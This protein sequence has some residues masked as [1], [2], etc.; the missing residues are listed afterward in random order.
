M[1]RVNP[2]GSLKEIN[3]DAN[4]KMNSGRDFSQKQ[5]A[6]VKGGRHGWKGEG[7]LL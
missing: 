2:Q 5:T 3:F 1:G 4:F 6:E 7:W